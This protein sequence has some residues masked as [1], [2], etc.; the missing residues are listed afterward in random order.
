[1]TGVWVG[2]LSGS[3]QQA[4]RSRGASQAA[5][6]AGAKPPQ[7]QPLVQ[8]VPVNLLYQSATG[9][10]AMEAAMAMTSLKL[11]LTKV[12]PS[13]FYAGS[14]MVATDGEWVAIKRILAD[15]ITI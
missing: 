3:S 4:L 8:H 12:L 5:G 7:P 14:Q 13:H 2:K 9:I 11:K 6:G 15:N 10:P 1:M